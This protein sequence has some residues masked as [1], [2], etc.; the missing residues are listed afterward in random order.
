MIEILKK[1][2]KKIPPLMQLAKLVD[3]W[4]KKRR[5]SSSSY[6]DGRYVNGGTSGAGF[7]GHLAEFKAS[8]LTPFVAEK[9]PE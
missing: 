2:I 8:V 6:W 1:N 9:A 3:S 4:R 5:F 7:Y